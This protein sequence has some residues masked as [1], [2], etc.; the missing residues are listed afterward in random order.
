MEELKRLDEHGAE[1]VKLRE[2]MVAG[3]RRHDEKIAKLRE[4][5]IAGFKRHD[6]ELTSLRKET[7]RLKAD[8]MKG[9]ESINR[10][11]DVLGNHE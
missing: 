1:L 6:E 4:D 11:L 3:F 7:N 10:R 2:D 8:M 9:F 5:I